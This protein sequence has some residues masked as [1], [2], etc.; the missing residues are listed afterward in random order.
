M[1]SRSTHWSRKPRR[2][3]VILE[4][5]N[6]RTTVSTTLIDPE[7]PFSPENLRLSQAFTETTAVKK[8]LNTIPVRKPGPQD[9]VRVRPG[10]N[11]RDNFSILE[12]R[13]EGEQYI[14]HAS[15]V[16]ELVGEVVPK[17]LL[18][19]INRQ[20]TVFFWPIRLPAADGKDN[21]YWR[22]AREAAELAINSWVR[23]KANQNLG[24]YDVHVAQSNF[25]EPEWPEL[26]YWD[27]IK[28]AFKDHLITSPD[29]PVV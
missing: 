7:D 25:A 18:L 29:H 15:M 24:A 19:A 16:P 1:R 12:V 8:V 5:K 23:V 9:F 26:A 3:P 4:P 14:V 6:R 11:F 20:G 13:D 2:S 22:S 21:D 27:L 17:Q 28:I 10:P